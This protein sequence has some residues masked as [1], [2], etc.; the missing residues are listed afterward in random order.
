[1]ADF[2]PDPAPG[3]AMTQEQ[4]D[5][6]LYV[7]AG[8]DKDLPRVHELLALGANPSAIGGGGWGNALHWASHFGHVDIVRVLLA[9]GAV[10]ESRARDGCT[11]LLL[12]AL[13]DKLEVVRLLIKKGADPLLKNDNGEDS[14]S[15]Y[16]DYVN[17]F[18]GIEH[19]VKMVRVAEIMS[20][21][22][23]MMV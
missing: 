9:H 7:A 3:E 15:C 17:N 2:D 20:L 21:W 14:L 4:L 6:A 18:E 19:Q 16:G 11:P 22:R 12:A 10:L 1:M 8:P 23:P 5:F 13:Y